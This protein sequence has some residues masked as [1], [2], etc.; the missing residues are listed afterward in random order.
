MATMTDEEKKRRTSFGDAA[1]ATSNP[2][3][4]QYAPNYGAAGLVP[5]APAAVSAAA[6][7][8][9]A[10]MGANLAGVRQASADEV[11]GLSAQGN[12]A[13]AIGASVRGDLASVPAFAADVG[14]AIAKDAAPVIGGISRFASGLFGGEAPAASSATANAPAAVGSTTKAAT[15]QTAGLPG[16]E[17]SLS[18]AN[19]PAATG[20][21]NL[22]GLERFRTGSGDITK[23][24]DAN[25]RTSYSGTNIG[26]GAT[27]NG[28]QAGGGY[29]EV[30]GGARGLAGFA[31]TTQPEQ[32]GLGIAPVI[33]HSGNDWQAR[34]DLRNAQIAATSLTNQ[35]AWA[36][37]N[38]AKANLAA[39]QSALDTDA[40]LRQGQP[41]MAQEAMRINA[42]YG[43]EGIRQAGQRSA[44]AG[45]HHADH[46]TKL[47]KKDLAAAG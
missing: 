27:I 47:S 10:Q 33:R 32:P 35:S 2:G 20:G 14:S 24:V 46:P 41:G 44:Q 38:A 19:M 4:I 22:A 18:P 17:N 16:Y 45:R 15:T 25:G 42:G 13:Q 21:S 30:P 1:A 36:D 28:Q 29:A 39:Y 31:A 26:P 37:P 34:N 40:K 23:T 6:P 3:L 11:R 43:I 7:A 8:A 12:T 5:R 9:P